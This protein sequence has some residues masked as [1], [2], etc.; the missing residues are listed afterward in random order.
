MQNGRCCLG[1]FCNARLEGLPNC[2]SSL[3]GRLNKCTDKL[4]KDLQPYASLA[5]ALLALKC[6]HLT[7]P[8]SR[9]QFLVMFMGK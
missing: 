3:A 9:Q 1:L 6:P 2:I 4:R 5:I 8:T 7:L